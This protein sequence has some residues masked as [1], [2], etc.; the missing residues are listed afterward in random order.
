MEKI[1][2]KNLIKILKLLKNTLTKYSKRVYSQDGED[3][4]LREFLQGRKKGFYVDIGAY[5]PYKFSNTY[6]FYKKGWRGINIDPMPGTMKL[7]NRHRK[8]DINLELGISRK[9]DKLTYYMFE[10]SALNG[11]S[12]NLT[13]ERRLK[14][15]LIGKKI[16]KTYPL[17]E[18]LENYMPKNTPID[19]MNVDVEG[20]DFEVLKSNDWNKYVPEFILVEISKKT[21]N[22]VFNDR[23]Y[24]F[25]LNKDY[26]LVTK[27]YRTCIFRKIK[28]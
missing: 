19:F 23:I 7:F 8:R 3:I 4:I 12:K 17:K 11:F 18:I 5:H 27:T 21:I 26:E 1:K 15:K 2:N 24:K 13:M 16:I 14:N 6:L 10:Q 28:K 9:R 20:F 22:E 25:L